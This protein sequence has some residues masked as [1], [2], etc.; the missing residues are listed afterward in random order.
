MH[1]DIRTL[2]AWWDRELDTR[3][4]ARVSRHMKGCSECR[5]RLDED[6]VDLDRQAGAGRR[7]AGQARPQL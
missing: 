4:S 5:E 1:P 3:K 6:D 2:L 7:C